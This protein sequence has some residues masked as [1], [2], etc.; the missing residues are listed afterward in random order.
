MFPLQFEM[1]HRA[2]NPHPQHPCGINQLP[3]KQALISTIVPRHCSTA[4]MR[5]RRPG[6]CFHQAPTAALT[7]AMIASRDGAS[8]ASITIRAAPPAF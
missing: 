1:A 7:A 3:D 2:T 6:N 4:R 5:A 8:T